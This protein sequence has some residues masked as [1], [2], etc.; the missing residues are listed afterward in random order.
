MGDTIEVFDRRAVR[1]HRER[2]A[3][4]PGHDALLR[5]V[6]GRIAERLDDVTHRFPLALDL[7]GRGGILARALQ[8]RGGI[9]TLVHCDLSPAMARLAAGDGRP[10][11]VA[12]E[13]ALPFAGERFDAVFSSLSLHWV[14]DLPGALLQVRRALRP[15]GLFLAALFGGGTLAELRGA[16]MQAEIEVEG[17]ASPR[18][19]PFV[20]VRDAGALLQRAGFA[21][22]VADV[23]SITADYPDAFGLMAELR[24]MGEANAVKDRRRGLTRRATL[25]RA[26]QIYAERHAGADGRLPATFQVIYLT[27][28]APH[29]SQQQPLAPGSARTRLSEA[30]DTEERSAGEEADP[31]FRG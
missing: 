15:D 6:A 16:L 24:G 30:L 2:A 10:S 17:G 8:G 18:V 19:S 4:L 9:E 22:A 12:D 28:W 27:A 23:D 29:E 1:H 26:A 3:G 5:E 13:E 11:V 31:K 14:N 7:G 25:M 20:D 21:L